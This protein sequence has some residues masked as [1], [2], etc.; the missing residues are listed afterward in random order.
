MPRIVIVGGGISGLTLAFRLQQA[1]PDSDITLLE[2][3][4]RPGGAIWTEEQDGFRFEIGP[5]GFLDTKPTT[6]ALERE[7]GSV[8]KG[9]ARSARQRHREAAAGGEPE[10]RPGRM[11]AFRRGLR[12]LIEELASK[13]RNRPLLGARVRRL[14]RSVDNATWVVHG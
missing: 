4:S 3:Q 9:L 7:Y 2:R 12:F 11:W 10:Q 1:L 6:M 14:E 13:L 5:N 8:I